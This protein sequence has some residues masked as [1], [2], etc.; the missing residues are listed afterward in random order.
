MTPA[1]DPP[2]T[3]RILLVEDS[4]DDAHLVRTVLR[5]AAVVIERVTSLGAALVALRSSTF[6]LILTDLGLPDSAG[7]GTVETLLRRAGVTPLVVLTGR[8]DD[9]TIHDAVEA[10]AQDVLVKGSEHVAPELLRAVRYALQRAKE[11]HDQNDE[12]IRSAHAKFR[13]LIDSSEVKIVLDV[14]RHCTY[15]S[16][17]VKALLGYE[18]A[19]LIGRPAHAFVGSLGVDSKLRQKDGTLIEVYSTATPMRNDDGTFTGTVVTMRNL[20]TQKKLEQEIEQTLRLAALGR[21]SASAVHEIDNLLTVVVQHADILRK[22]TEH[23]EALAKPIALIRDAAR[24]GRR[25]SEQI[26]R[27]TRPPEPRFDSIDV[28]RWLEHVADEAKGLVEGRTLE[29]E[30]PQAL[31]IRGDRDLLSQVLFNLLKNARDATPPGG[32]VTIG[33]ARAE[34][35]PFV[36]ERLG[37][38]EH[39]AAIFVHDNGHGIPPEARERLFE[40]L[41]TTKPDSTGFGLAT[42]DRIVAQ[43]GGRIF[44]ETEPGAGSTFYVALRRTDGAVR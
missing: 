30:P 20:K 31:H 22:R 5:N 34:T 17:S 14:Y 38:A 9:D 15:A 1:P 42:S 19:E 4:D 2:D 28:R 40:P 26:L 35:T 25:V 36:R 18:P 39:F 24:R 8:G 11:R 3:P 21:V 23:D 43:H 10:G 13:A 27:F 29:L 7:T 41:F 33:A 6:D 16:P 44:V 32:V 12:E 37:D